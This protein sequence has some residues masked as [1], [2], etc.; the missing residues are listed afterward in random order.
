[1]IAKELCVKDPSCR[2]QVST[3]EENLVLLTTGRGQPDTLAEIKTVAKTIKKTAKCQLGCSIAGI[4]LTSLQYFKSEYAAHLTG[5]CPGLTCKELIRYEVI[6]ALCKDCRCCYLVC[7]TE[8]VKHR[9]GDKRFF[10]DDS[11]CIKCGSCAA[12]CP[13]GC[14]KPISETK[15]KNI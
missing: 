11:L 15:Q 3:L 5:L 14:I 9:I 4:L 13:C 8:A 10:V 2:A 12:T 7:P 1:M 6:Q